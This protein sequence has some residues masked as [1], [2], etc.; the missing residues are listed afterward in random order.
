MHR[1]ARS[2]RSTSARCETYHRGSAAARPQRSQL[3]RVLERADDARRARGRA[4]HDARDVGGRERVMI[5]ERDARRTSRT[6]VAQLREERLR[7]ADRRRRRRRARPASASSARDVPSRAS[8]SALG[9]RCTT[10][11]PTRGRRCESLG[12]RA[13]RRSRDALLRVTIDDV[14]RAQRARAARATGPPAA[15]AR[16]PRA[17]L[18]ATRA[19]SP[20]C[21]RRADAGTRRRAPRSPRPRARASRAPRTRSA[22][23]MTGT[24]GFS[25]RARAARR[26]RSRAARSPAARRAARSSRGGPRGD[27]RLPGAADGQVADAEHGNRRRVR[28]QHVRDRTARRA[29]ARPRRT[30]SSRRR[31]RGARRVAR[32]TT[33]PYQIA[34]ERAS[35]LS[36]R[37]TASSSASQPRRL[38]GRLARRVGLDR[39]ERAVRARR[40]ARTASG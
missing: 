36:R 20:R 7:I 28:A 17:T 14:A 37:G 25:A 15:V 22:S 11:A 24:S 40:R 39:V 23:T 12:D 21:A 13:R 33:S 5:A 1:A 31:E 10:A 16:R 4:S 27:R 26:R 38:L 8:T 3:D 34:L 35:S 6:G 9:A 29:S 32:R 19:P 18:G 2:P 30:A